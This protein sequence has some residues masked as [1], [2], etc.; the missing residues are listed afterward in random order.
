MKNTNMKSAKQQ[1]LKLEMMSLFAMLCLSYGNVA[2][3]EIKIECPPSLSCQHNESCVQGSADFLSHPKDGGKPLHFHEESIRDGAHCKCH[4]G[5]TGLECERKYKTCGSGHKCYHGSECVP[6][7]HDAFGN[8]QHF[9]DCHNAVD[10]DGIRYVGKW[11]EHPVVQRCNNTNDPL[12]NFLEE[13]FCVNGGSCNELYPQSGPPCQCSNGFEGPHCEFKVGAVP[14]CTLKCKNNGHCHL[15]I[16]NPDQ[17]GSPF[18]GD[19]SHYM[20]CVCPPGFEG[21][22]C[23]F[24][25]A[26]ETVE[27][28]DT[29]GQADSTEKG[30]TTAAVGTGTNEPEGVTEEQIH[31]GEKQDSLLCTTRPPG[32]GQPF[33]FCVNGGTCMAKVEPGEEHP[34][35]NCPEDQFTGPHCEQTIRHDKEVQSDQA[36]IPKVISAKY[37]PVAR[38]IISAFFI[39]LGSAIILVAYILLHRTRVEEEMEIAALDPLSDNMNLSVAKDPDDMSLPPFGGDDD[40]ALSR[41]SYRSQSYKGDDFLGSNYH[42]EPLQAQHHE[43]SQSLFVD[44]GPPRDEDGNAL[45]EVTIV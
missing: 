33:S 27:N 36:N 30:D 18:S 41:C 28:E 7:I 24:Q 44:I 40:D 19:N 12:G 45:H 34:G 10:D 14:A 32:P 6:G 43:S 38:K 8:T 23:E 21:R 25:S 39:G 20:H 15:G 5:W 4:S 37:P 11:C 9:C 35:C 17:A 29:I 22:H 42:D 1:N 26:E 16:Q 3:A 2:V 31:L 13:A